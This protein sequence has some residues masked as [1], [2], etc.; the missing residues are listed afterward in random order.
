MTKGIVKITNILLQC[1]YQAFPIMV[2]VNYRGSLVGS[3]SQMN[4]AEVGILDSVPPLIY[5][6]Q[7]EMLPLALN[8]S[9]M[10]SG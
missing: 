5:C 3:K 8:S 6:L 2:K 7:Y 4:I 9:D 10:P 1:T